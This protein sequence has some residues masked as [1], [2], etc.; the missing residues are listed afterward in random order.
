M[1]FRTGEG[2]YRRQ[3]VRPKWGLH[4]PDVELVAKGVG[5]RAGD[6][7]GSEVTDLGQSGNA[8]FDP[9]WTVRE[10]Q[11]GEQPVE[12]GFDQDA[13]VLEDRR[14]AAHLGATD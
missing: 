5:Q 8:I 11:T 4:Q 13:A 10:A 9:A 12:P 7:R 14:S 6:R 1:I 2:P 3:L